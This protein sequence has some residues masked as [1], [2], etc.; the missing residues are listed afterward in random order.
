MTAIRNSSATDLPLPACAGGTTSDPDRPMTD[1]QQAEQ[2]PDTTT[3]ATTTEGPRVTSVLA[4]KIAAR[5]QAEFE[6]KQARRADSVRCYW[7][8][9]EDLS[10]RRTAKEIAA[11]GDA[12]EALGRS[13]ADLEHDAKAIADLRER[14]IKY[15]VEDAVARRDRTNVEAIAEQRRIKAAYL[16]LEADEA[17]LRNLLGDARIHLEGALHFATADLALL[18]GLRARGFQGEVQGR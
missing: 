12:L 2:T 13:P 11:I 4:A 16:Q 5:Q 1:L 9:A 7:A 15:R 8:A 6:A 10:A 14:A 3:T 17:S 18:T